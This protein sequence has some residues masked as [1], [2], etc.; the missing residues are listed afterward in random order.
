MKSGIFVP[1][2]QCNLVS[3]VLTEGSTLIIKQKVSC[4]WKEIGTNLFFLFLEAV[5]FEHK[6][7]HMVEHLTSNLVQGAGNLTNSDIKSSNARVRP[8]GMLTEFSN[9]LI[10]NKLESNK[11]GGLWFILVVFCRTEGFCWYYKLHDS[12]VIAG[13]LQ[14]KSKE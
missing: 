4:E 1:V 10:H 8:G 2:M 5:L 11:A 7:F 6:S 14:T 9:L 12:I 13:N 3:C